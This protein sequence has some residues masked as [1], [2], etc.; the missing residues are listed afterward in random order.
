MNQQTVKQ[1]EL[2]EGLLLP[3]K[4]RYKR[5]KEHLAGSIQGQPPQTVAEGQIQQQQEEEEDF[6][7]LKKHSPKLVKYTTSKISG[8]ANPRRPRV[9]PEYQAIIPEWTGP[10]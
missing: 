1:A 7:Y 6:V 4:Q 5:S 2:Q 3:P 9:G 8:V 10:K